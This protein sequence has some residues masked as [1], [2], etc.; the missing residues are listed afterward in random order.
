[1]PID[2]TGSPHTHPERSV[3]SN[4]LRP[5]TTTTYVPSR[6]HH[7]HPP[8]KMGVHTLANACAHLQNASKARLGLT[9][10]PNTKYNLLFCLALHRAGLL[11]SVTRGGPTPP[12]PEDMHKIEPEPVTSA[13]VASRRL[14]L[15]LKY[16]DDRPVLREVEVISK[17]TRIV[18]MKLRPLQKVVAGFPRGYVKGLSLGEN[19][20][21]STQYGV[22]EAREA[23]ARN[24]S[25]MIICRTA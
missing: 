21:V 17:P 7:R 14:W 19:L 13:N 9:S 8:H 24:T 18:T 1:M 5:P 25:G 3:A 16:W 15:G 2:S 12:A 23:I 20:F 22:L 10:L 11:S 4:F 6:T